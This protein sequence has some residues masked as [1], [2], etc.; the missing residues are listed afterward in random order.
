VSSAAQEQAAELEPQELA[1]E[2]LFRTEVYYRFLSFH[3]A[4]RAQQSSSV[5]CSRQSRRTRGT[6]SESSSS[7]NSNSSDVTAQRAQQALGQMQHARDFHRFL[8]S[9]PMNATRAQQLKNRTARVRRALGRGLSPQPSEQPAFRVAG[10]Q[11]HTHPRGHGTPGAV[12]PGALAC[13]VWGSGSPALR[14]SPRVAALM[15][16][17]R[18]GGGRERE[19]VAVDFDLE[20]PAQRRRVQLAEDS[21]SRPLPAPLAGFLNMSESPNQTHRASGS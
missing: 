16:Q 17:R 13:G 4:L 20:R 1:D 15:E 10:A 21:H 2:D 18:G 8:A 14:R 11:A 6:A 7:S 12:A 3:D 5:G 9:F 19:R